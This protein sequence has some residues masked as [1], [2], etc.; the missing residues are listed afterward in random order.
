MSLRSQLHVL[1]MTS[2]ALGAGA[3]ASHQ[4]TEL[5]ATPTTIS[6]APVAA[7]GAGFH[8]SATG[9]YAPPVDDAQIAQLAALANER[10]VELG[11][12]A[13]LH[14][15]NVRVRE[16]A[17][18]VAFAHASVDDWMRALLRNQA[19]V[20]SASPESAAFAAA[21]QQAFEGL[22][23]T[24]SAAFDMAYVDAQV[25]SQQALLD[26]LDARLIP[27][28]QNAGLKADLQG[29]RR[30]SADLLQEALDVRRTLGKRHEG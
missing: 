25:K 14:A 29:A 18:H 1:F 22:R 4:A 3:C 8:S 21:G 20:P 6:S 17:R 13:V 28:A 23:S 7:P 16:L 11:R 5:P 12:Y 15:K 19:I 9:A 26:L 2:L 24:S 30:V 10:E 27:K